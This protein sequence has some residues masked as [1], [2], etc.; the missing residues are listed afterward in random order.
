MKSIGFSTIAWLLFAA[1]GAQSTPILEGIPVSPIAPVVCFGHTNA[2]VIRNQMLEVTVLPALGR[3]AGLRFGGLDNVVRFDDALAHAAAN[4]TAHAGWRNY[5]GDWL[6]VVPQAHWPRLFGERWPPPPF[7]D[8]LPWRGH[9]WSNADRTQNI[10]LQLELGEPVHA[11]IQRH[12]RIDP[13]TATLTIRQR[14]ERTAASTIPLTLWNISQVPGARRVL[15]P[16]ENDSLFADGYSILDF[17][18]PPSNLL[19]RTAGGVLL[20]D[21]MH[22]T[23][24]KLGSDSPRNWIAA[25]RGNV[26]I[27]EQATTRKAGGDFPDGGCRVE[28]YANSGLGYTEIETLSEERTLAVGEVM[29]NTLTFSFYHVKPDLDDEALAQRV[30]EALGEL[31]PATQP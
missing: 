9:A 28:L 14:I 11:R 26:L 18:P 10:Q 27:I 8:G 23:E 2:L 7:L 12:L 1:A 15:M 25:Q 5:G 20:L 6:F 17:G 31:P 21:V 16:V 24:H 29:E 3:I 4:G 13:E 19:T 22:G 30:R